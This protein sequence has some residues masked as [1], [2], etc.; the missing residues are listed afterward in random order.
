[1]NRYGNRNLYDYMLYR[2]EP[3]DVAAHACICIQT[4]HIIQYHNISI[5]KH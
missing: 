3:M 2:Y 5:P 1:M 4:S